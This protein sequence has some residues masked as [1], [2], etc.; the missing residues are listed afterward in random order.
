MGGPVRVSIRAADIRG[1]CPVHVQESVILFRFDLDRDGLQ[2]GIFRQF[3][4]LEDDLFHL[5]GG[6]DPLFPVLDALV[7]KIDAYKA[8]LVHGTDTET[9]GEVVVHAGDIDGAGNGVAGALCGN[10]LDVAAFF[11]ILAAM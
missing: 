9:D 3:L 10:K 1:P 5:A 8:V 4:L 2:I 7:V 11:F 6:H